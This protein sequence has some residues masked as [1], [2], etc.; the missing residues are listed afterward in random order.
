MAVPEPRAFGG[1]SGGVLSS[2]HDMAA[3][4]IAHNNHGR[5]PGGAA[6]VSAASIDTMRTP[7]AASRC[8]WARMVRRHH[9]LGNAER[10]A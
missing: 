8:V 3:W 4:L 5:G 6:I 2:A 9:P 1:G 10:V 7:T